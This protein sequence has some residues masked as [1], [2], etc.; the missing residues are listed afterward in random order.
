MSMH[1]NTARAFDEID[2]AA[3]SGDTFLRKANR[4]KLRTYVARWTRFLTELDADDLAEGEDDTEI[5]I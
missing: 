1:P 2:A 5:G 4:E 3:F